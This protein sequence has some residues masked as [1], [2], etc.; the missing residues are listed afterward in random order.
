[1]KE[2]TLIS[3]RVVNWKKPKRSIH[4]RYARIVDTYQ[5]KRAEA[6][7]DVSLEDSS[8]DEATR[9]ANLLRAI[10][11]RGIT[12]LESLSEEEADKFLEYGDALIKDSTGEEPDS[13]NEDEWWQLLSFAQH[14]EP[15]TP[16]Q[17]TEGE[18]TSAE[19][20]SFPDESGVS[21]ESESVED[22]RAES[23][24]EDGNS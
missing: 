7:R 8:E 1:M 5:R 4:W 14:G 21:A 22:V 18:V 24:G 10:V 16:V 15:N 12:F 19:V 11:E 13:F 6:A 23:I 3:G 9:K 20:E 2:I 17:T